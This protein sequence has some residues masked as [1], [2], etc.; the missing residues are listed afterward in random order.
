MT[1]VRHFALSCCLVCALGGMVRIFWPENRF[2]PVINTV[3][4]LY[5]VASVLSMWS[6]ADWQ[7]LTGALRGWARGTDTV[8]YSA[9]A[10]ELGRTAA[11]QAIAAQL[12]AQGITAAVTVTEDLCT[13]ALGPGA[14]AAA[15]EAIV[16]AACGT[17]PYRITGGEAP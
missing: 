5:I 15:A 3:L 11:A 12:Q 8:D 7:G 10:A 9:Y 4:V 14:D 13:V 1:Q 16:R 17:L 6:G 2:K